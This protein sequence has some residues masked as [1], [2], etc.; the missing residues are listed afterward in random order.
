MP[1]A[2]CAGPRAACPHTFLN[3]TDEAG[4]CEPIEDA[5]SGIHR[6]VEPF[7]QRFD[8]QRDARVLNDPVDH[9]LHDRG[10]HGNVSPFSFTHSTGPEPSIVSQG[11]LNAVKSSARVLENTAV[12]LGK[13][14]AHLIVTDE[15]L[16]FLR[17]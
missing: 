12:L 1:V 9:S 6:N 13:P 8:C 3:F 10:P 5:F 2:R 15:N 17:T 4:R 11:N 14:D 16:R 7:L